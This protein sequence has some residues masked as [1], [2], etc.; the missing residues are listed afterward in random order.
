[1]S[2]EKP[3]CKIRSNRIGHETGSKLGKEYVN[4]V[5][6]HPAYLTYILYS[7]NTS[8]EMPGWM[9]HK[10]ESRL[11][12]EIASDMQMTHPYGR[13]WRGTKE[14]LNESERGEWE[15]WLKAQ[16]SKNEDHGI[17]SHHFMASRWGNSGNSDRLYFLGAPK[18][19]KLV[20]A[21]MKLKDAYSLE[22]KLWPT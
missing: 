14:P 12:G 1:M 2:T 8:C 22:G 4:A 11:L 20:I 3:V 16:H 19:L 5:Y 15:S 18:S 17:Y 9:K 21:A 13:K 6:C 10:L 7:V